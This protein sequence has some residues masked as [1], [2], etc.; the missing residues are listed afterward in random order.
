MGTFRRL[1]YRGSGVKLTPLL[2]V[3]RNYVLQYKTCRLL[4]MLYVRGPLRGCRG[5]GG[6]L[7]ESRFCRDHRHGESFLLRCPTA[8]SAFKSL[9]HLPT[10]ATRS[11]RFS[12]TSSARIAPQLLTYVYSPRICRITMLFILK[13][14][15]LYS[16]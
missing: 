10:A 13:G 1:Q 12:A 14:E 11:A 7:W 8:S 3:V 9:P 16:R 2:L 6:F 15:D 5:C 4:S